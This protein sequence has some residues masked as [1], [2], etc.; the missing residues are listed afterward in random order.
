MRPV[1][2]LALFTDDLAS[3]IAFYESVLGGAPAFQSEHMALFQ[4]DGLHILIHHKSTDSPDYE[5]DA[6][7]P[8]NEESLCHRSEGFWTLY[9]PRV[10]LAR[11]QAR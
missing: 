2:E 5:V 7:G 4:L 1:V 9:G 8:P 3:L 11:L 6:D 10:P